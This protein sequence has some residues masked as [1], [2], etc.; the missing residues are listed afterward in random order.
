[1]RRVEPSIR[2]S[3]SDADARAAHALFVRRIGP[4]YVEDWPSFRLTALEENGDWL[5][6]LGLA[7]VDGRLAAAQL[8]G[9]LPAAQMLSLPYT[10]VAEPF[11]GQGVYLALKRAML[12]ELGA[13]AARRGLPPPLGNIAEEAPGSAQFRRK[14]EGGIATV[15][16]FAYAQPTAQGLTEMPLALTFEPLVHPPPA[17]GADDYERIVA[18]IYRGLYRIAHPEENPTYQRIAASIH[19]EH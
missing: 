14:V 13:R 11:E 3:G 10:A 1:M 8:G 16:P 19:D 17:Y 12:A 9:L 2:F 6:C 15:L 5:P 4:R 18:S 7:E